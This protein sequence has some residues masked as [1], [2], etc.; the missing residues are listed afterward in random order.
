M[1]REARVGGQ[2]AAWLA[3]FSVDQTIAAGLEEDIERIVYL[4]FDQFEKQEGP[5]FELFKDIWQKTGLGQ[6]F[7]GRESFR[8]MY[9]F[10]EE[11]L[12]RVKRFAMAELHKKLNHQLVRSAGRKYSNLNILFFKP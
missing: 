2:Q 9:E 11:L 5:R 10:T 4:A 1:E 6:L 7:S 12:A 3:E 8:E